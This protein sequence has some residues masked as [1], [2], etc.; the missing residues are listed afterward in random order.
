MIIEKN[1]KIY[2]V[3]ETNSKWSLKSD[4][5]KISIVYDVPKEMCKSEEEL[6][7]YVLTNDVF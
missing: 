5:G 6:R 1:G 3:A 2:T 4:S 7:D